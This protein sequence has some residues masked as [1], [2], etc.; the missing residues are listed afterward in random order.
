MGNV[1]MCVC[2]ACTTGACALYYKDEDGDT[3]G[4]ANG[5]VANGRAAYGCAA[6][7]A[8]A[9]FVADK[10]D[11]Y[12][13]PLATVAKDVHPNQAAFFPTAYTPPGGSATFDYNCN[14][15]EQKE[16]LEFPGSIGCGFCNSV[17]SPAIGC[18]FET[19]CKNIAAQHSGLAC[20]ARMGVGQC[21]VD[22]TG[23]GA[24][25]HTTTGFISLVACGGSA[26]KY[27]CNQCGALNTVNAPT[28]TA[29][30]VQQCH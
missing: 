1:G 24:G 23:L 15:S 29:T 12:D 16:T 18:N 10:T 30:V 5:T 20:Q 28:T 22:A 25:V 21:S 2:P 4:D 14:G 6:G 3:Y 17:S 27:T 7:P 26:T 11:C 19:T 13:G 9:G 8:P